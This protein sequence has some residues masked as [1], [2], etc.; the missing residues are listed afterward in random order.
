MN[1]NG[2]FRWR[3][4][5]DSSCPWTL[6]LDHDNQVEADERWVDFLLETNRKFHHIKIDGVLE[7]RKNRLFDIFQKHG[8]SISKLFV[9]ESCFDRLDQFVELLKCM[10]NLDHLIL[11]QITTPC[12]LSDVPADDK[13]PELIKLKTLELVETDSS[14]VKCFKR[15]KLKVFKLLGYANEPKSMTQDPMLELFKSQS[16]IKTLALR[17]IDWGTS[18]L[19]QT[20][21]MDGS[22]KFQLSQLSLIDIKLRESPNDYN[23]LL[24]FLKPQAKTIKFLEIGRSFPDLVYEFVFAKFKNL[25]SLRLMINELPKDLEFYERLEENQSITQL[26]FIDSPPP[27]HLNNGCPPSLKEFI[28][29]VPNVT[30]LTLI[31]YCDRGTLQ[32]IAGN[33]KNLKSLAV[34]YF[35]EAIFGGLQFPNLDILCVERL[36]EDVDW[37]QFTKNNPDITEIII[38]TGTFAGFSGWSDT[39]MNNFVEHV[40]KNLRLHTLRIGDYF[41]ANEHFYEILRKQGAEM[42]VVDLHVACALESHMMN[43]ISALRFHEGELQKHF[44]DLEFWNEDDYDGRLPDIDR[45]GNWDDGENFLDPF[46]MHLMDI[47]D[48]DEYDQQ[49]DFYDDYDNFVDEFD[50]NSDYDDYV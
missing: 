39:T 10:P 34:S 33:M 49:D 25:K 18:T 30:E 19:F 50:E 23:N 46:D 12:T 17:N 45:G 9:F 43:G 7:L 38:H 4:L 35:S 31:E 5:I 41:R 8:S 37:D 3:E 16:Q 21:I 14:I 1:F 27:N 6:S 44:N 13:L 20:D 42:K 22:V 24:K 29:H 40:T 28:Q 2:N 26:I 36:D 48:Y 32:F 11:Y 15:A 47:D